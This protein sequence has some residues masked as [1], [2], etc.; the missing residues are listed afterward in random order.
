M[1]T[2]ITQT[3]EKTDEIEKDMASKELG[4]EIKRLRLKAG[5]EQEDL[6]EKIGLHQS[7]VSKLERG[8]HNYPLETIFRLA[9]AFEINPFELAAVYW[10]IE[11]TE[12]P[13]RD[14][15]LLN[16]LLK[17]FDDYRRFVHA[18]QE[19]N[20]GP[21]HTS[22]KTPHQLIE[23][24]KAILDKQTKSNR[25]AKIKNPPPTDSENINN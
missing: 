12:L 23:P 15:E 14:K 5:W 18:P 11:V 17:L 10:G 24:D 3:I 21:P 19:T 20:P 25:K 7:R 6:A 1:D 22:N 2:T 4:A 8:E 9:K 13:N 16:S